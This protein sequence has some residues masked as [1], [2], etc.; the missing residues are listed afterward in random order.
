[1]SNKGKI[2]IP[3]RPSRF[4]KL[5]KSV[6]DDKFNGFSMADTGKRYPAGMPHRHVLEQ[7]WLRAR[8]K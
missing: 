2:Y 1:M 5:R 6:N 7:K 3:K 4:I 8:G